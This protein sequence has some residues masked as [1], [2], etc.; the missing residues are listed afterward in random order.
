VLKQFT[1]S[2]TLALLVHVSSAK[3]QTA[4]PPPQ[5]AANDLRITLLGRYE[6]TDAKTPRFG[7]PGSGFIVRFQGK[8]LAFDVT[9]DSTTSALTLV[10]DHKEP[11]LLLLRKGEQTIEA[12]DG[13]DDATHTL[14]VYKRTETW[15]GLVTL[16]GLRPTSSE[17]LPSPPLPQ[18]KL[19]FLGDSVT[20][21]AGIDNNDKCTADPLRP[22][23]DPYDSYGMRLGRRLDAQVQLVCY[24]GRGLERD[25]RGLGIGDGVLNL[26]EFMDLAIATDDATKRVP[27]DTTAYIPD[28]IVVSIGTNDFNLQPTKPLDGEKFVTDYVALLRHVLAEYPDAKIFATEGA[29]VTNPLLRTYIQRAVA[30]VAQS[31]VVWAPSTH[32]PGNGC[33][34]H[35]TR[36]QHAHM[37]DDFEPILRNSLHW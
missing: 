20:C 10:V 25:Y 37:T 23:G 35:P 27:W 33:N 31:R 32:Y 26:P 21:G 6:M 22:N 14:E 18:R 24:G 19:M 4:P 34:G 36:S 28:G 16:L 11:K 5:I 3:S 2:V 29:I 12:A 9:S 17:L 30:E 13:L 15:Q 1:L 8:T 7:Y